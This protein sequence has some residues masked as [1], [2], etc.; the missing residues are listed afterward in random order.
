MGRPKKLEKIR[1]K[2]VVWIYSLKNISKQST[3]ET[4]D[5]QKL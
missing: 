2:Q 4:D 3:R 5:F 1:I